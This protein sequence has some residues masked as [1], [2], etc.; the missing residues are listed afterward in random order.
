MRRYVVNDL[1]GGSFMEWTHETPLTRSELI[2]VF[3]QFADSDGMQMPNR[4]FT[5]R[6]CAL[7]WEVEI[8]PERFKD[9]GLADH[10]NAELERPMFYN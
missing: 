5:L 10:Y 1:Q 8:L 2:R 3:K 9:K 4:L 6:H 7:I